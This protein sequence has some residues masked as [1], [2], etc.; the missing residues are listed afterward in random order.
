[1]A[2]YEFVPKGVCSKRIKF[3]IDD[4]L[5]IRNLSFQGGCAGNLKAIGKIV[6]GLPAEKVASIFKGNLCGDKKTSCAD[7]L[8]IALGL[9]LQSKKE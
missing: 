5:N 6:E 8:A 9:A 1:M 3:E 4:D 7:Q 2:K